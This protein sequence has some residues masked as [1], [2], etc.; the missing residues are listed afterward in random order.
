MENVID[1][2]LEMI[3]LDAVKHRQAS[4]SEAQSAGYVLE[5]LGIKLKQMFGAT[6]AQ[7]ADGRTVP[8]GTRIMPDSFVNTFLITVQTMQGL[9]TSRLKDVIQTK[10]KVTEINLLETVVIA[11]GS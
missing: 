2:I 11:R 1:R 3:R 5:Q 10:F 7:Y 9:P 4:T 8:E 6:H